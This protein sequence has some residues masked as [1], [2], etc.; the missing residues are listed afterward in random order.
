MAQLFPGFA[1]AAVL[2]DGYRTDAGPH[3]IDIEVAVQGVDL[4]GD[5]AR[6]SA[7]KHGDPGIAGERGV[8]HLDP[9]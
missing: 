6:E 3:P 7:F 9:A 8:L 5:E 4:V 1:G 2:L